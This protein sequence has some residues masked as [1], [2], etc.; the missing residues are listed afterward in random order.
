MAQN[1]QTIVKLF[2][3]FFVF[4]VALIIF[5]NTMPVLDPYYSSDKQQYLDFLNETTTITNFIAVAEN[6]QEGSKGFLE[7]RGI[8]NSAVINAFLGVL[9]VITSQI[10]FILD[11]AMSILFTPTTMLNILLYEFIATPGEYIYFVYTIVNMLFYVSLYYITFK[12]RI[13]QN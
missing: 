6:V 13:S 2:A 8:F 9:N 12:R 7:D 1:I 3:V 4:Q 10:A 5:I 11:L